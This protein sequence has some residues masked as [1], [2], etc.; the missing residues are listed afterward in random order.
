[1]VSSYFIIKLGYV[2][3]LSCK[4]LKLM[5]VVPYLYSTSGLT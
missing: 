2:N 4:N 5:Q 3:N 1:M